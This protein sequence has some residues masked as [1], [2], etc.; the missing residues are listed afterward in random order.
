MILTGPFKRLAAQGRPDAIPPARAQSISLSSEDDGNLRVGGMTRA[1]RLK[2]AEMIERNTGADASQVIHTYPDGWTLRNPTTY[3]DWE[4]EG[5]LMGNCLSEKSDFQNPEWDN[6]IGNY[7]ETHGNYDYV[8]LRDPDNLPHVTL[9]NPEGDYPPS[10]YEILGQHNNTPKP[11][12][13]HKILDWI[14]QENPDNPVHIE[15][16]QFHPNQIK[17][18]MK[19]QELAHGAG[20]KWAP[21]YSEAYPMQS[22]PGA[23]GDWGDDF[24]IPGVFGAIDLQQIECPTCGDPLV[25][26]DCLRC[27]WGKSWGDENTWGPTEN[28]RDPTRDMHRGI[29][30]AWD[31]AGEP[32][33][34]EELWGRFIPSP[35]HSWGS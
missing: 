24:Q 29:Q 27:N 31:D 9:K 35:R 3:G 18:W 26:G 8:S 6:F 21:Q 32:W 5:S 13:M 20:E 7:G 14:N 12:Y 22:E 23:N 28:P 33:E 11:V 16:Q 34:A 30:S 25:N 4:R 2:L 1:Q 15:A 10:Y 17:D 19:D